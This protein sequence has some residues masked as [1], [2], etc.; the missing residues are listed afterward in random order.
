MTRKR[1][2]TLFMGL[3]MLAIRDISWEKKREERDKV[4]DKERKK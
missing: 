4:R 2:I 3:G 1:R